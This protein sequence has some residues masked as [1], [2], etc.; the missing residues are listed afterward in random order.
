MQFVRSLDINKFI[1]SALLFAALAV[2]TACGGSAAST[3]WSGAALNNDLLYYGGNDAHLFA[4]EAATGAYKWVYPAE[5]NMTGL[6]ATPTVEN[7]TIYIGG[8]DGVMR[9]VDAKSGAQ[10][11]QFP[12]DPNLAVYGP[13]VPTALVVNGMVYYGDNLHNFYALNAADGTIKWQVTTGNKIWSGPVYDNGTIYVGSMDHSLYAFDAQTGAEKWKYGADGL[14]AG[15]PRVSNGVVYFGA[16][17]SLIAVDASTGQ[18]KWTFKSPNPNEWIWAQP[19]VDQNRVYVGT[20]MGNLLA[21]DARTGDKIWELPLSSGA[22]I[23]SAVVVDGDTGYFGAADQNVYAVTLSTG[24]LKWKTPDKSL[25]GPIYTTPTLRDGILY[26]PVQG[27]NMYALN[28]SD[29]TRKWCFDGSSRQA[30]GN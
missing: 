8:Y 13:I 3:G 28:A 10:R 6:Y 7:D 12:V 5:H 25:A 16:L 30:C 9:A 14:I 21:L 2:L 19:T 1:V 11:W 29:G 26:I 23:R 20:L 18:L 17:N 15:A 22:E 4:L 27:H 24:Q